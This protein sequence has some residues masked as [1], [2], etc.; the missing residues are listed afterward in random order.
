MHNALWNDDGEPHTAT[1]YLSTLAKK[2]TANDQKVARILSLTNPTLTEVLQLLGTNSPFLLSWLSQFLD[3]KNIASLK[4]FYEGFQENIDAVLSDPVVVY[5]NAAL[6]L[7]EYKQLP[8]HDEQLLA[9]HATCTVDRLRSVLK[10]LLS[11]SLISFD[12]KKYLPSSFDFSF[13]G[14]AHPKLRGLTKYTTVLAAERYPST[15][16]M[17]DPTRTFNPGRGSVRVKAFSKDAAQKVSDLITKFHNEVEQ[18]VRQDT[19]PKT[20]VQIVLVHSF[21]STI[22]SPFRKTSRSTL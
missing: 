10:L 1:S 3:C 7:Q 18:I 2:I 19:Q 13:S 11:H 8:E 21:P 16:L 12:G 22:N 20:N 9:D 14:L 17:I 15:P 5:V 6:N 4:D